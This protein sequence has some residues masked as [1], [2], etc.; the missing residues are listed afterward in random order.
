MVE[1]LHRSRDMSQSRRRWE[2]P[3]LHAGSYPE[4]YTILP[5]PPDAPIPETRAPRERFSWL[6]DLGLEE[7]S[8]DHTPTGELREPTDVDGTRWWDEDDDEAVS[9]ERPPC[10]H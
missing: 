9:T 7:L 1:G 10:L 6:H 3:T 8:E 2:E 5:P 4:R